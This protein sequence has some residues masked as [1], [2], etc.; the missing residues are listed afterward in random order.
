MFFSGPESSAAIYWEILVHFVFPSAHK[1]M[2]IS[3]SSRTAAH[4]AKITSDWFADRG[5]TVLDWPDNWPDLNRR[6]D[7]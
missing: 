4:S 7:L 6:E 2:L 3:F 1:L 5:I